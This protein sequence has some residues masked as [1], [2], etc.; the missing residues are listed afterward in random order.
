MAFKD[1]NG[2]WIVTGVCSFTG[3][4]CDVKSPNVYSRVSYF[5]SWITQTMEDFSLEEGEI[6]NFYE[7]IGNTV[8]TVGFETTSTIKT[9]TNNVTNIG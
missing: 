4:D 1:E 8:E 6:K 2:N 5:R 3:A 7:I 9:A